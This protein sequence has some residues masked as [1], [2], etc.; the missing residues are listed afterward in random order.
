MKLGRRTA[1]Q[2]LEV[3]KKEI[4]VSR[5]RRDLAVD[6]LEAVA[7]VA[8]DLH[9]QLNTKPG[10]VTVLSCESNGGEK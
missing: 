5:F 9:R 8:V 3:L 1:E 6:D 2:V 4:R 7:R 10:K